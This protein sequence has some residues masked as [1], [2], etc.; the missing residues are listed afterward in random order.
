MNICI[1]KTKIF[2]YLITLYCLICK[3]FAKIE[4]LLIGHA[5]ALLFDQNNFVK[6]I[7]TPLANSN[8][9]GVAYLRVGPWMGPFTRHFA[10]IVPKNTKDLDIFLK[11]IEGQERGRCIMDPFVSMVGQTL[12]NNTGIRAIKERQQLLNYTGNIRLFY[13]IIQE[14]FKKT[15]KELAELDNFV[16]LDVIKLAV[17]QIATRG[18]IGGKE[19]SESE[20]QSI[21]LCFQ[22]IKEKISHPYSLKTM[23]NFLKHQKM[24]KQASECFIE[25]HQD[26][27]RN[28]LMSSGTN[29]VADIINQRNLNNQGIQNNQDIQMAKHSMLIV[30]ALDGIYINLVGIIL[31]LISHPQILEKLRK[32]LD[33]MSEQDNDSRTLGYDSLTNYDHKP[34]YL[35]NVI[36]EGLRY[37]SSAPFLPRYCTSKITQGS[38]KLPGYTTILISLEAMHHNTDYWGIDHDQFDPDRWDKLQ[39]ERFKSDHFLPFSTGP[40]PCPGSNIGLIALRS[41]ISQLFLNY[42]VIPVPDQPGP[43]ICT[44]SA[45][46]MDIGPGY[47]V[48]LKKRKR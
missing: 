25:N 35:D 44:E 10:V 9:Q 8:P 6:T 26:E 2:S 38:I 17:R 16:L 23:I 18:M 27:I 37:I 3:L 20:N 15:F 46:I 43:R 39:I 5:R 12:S 30:G 32:E 1:I 31:Q 21:N 45:L 24:Y 4:I 33:S 14:H 29:V 42:D 11:E 34:M 41:G 28:G 7:L 47:K 13:P 40:R 19:F 36:R 48:W 22:G